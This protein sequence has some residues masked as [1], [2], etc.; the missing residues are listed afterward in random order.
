MSSHKLG[1]ITIDDCP[2]GS[3]SSL[4]TCWLFQRIAFVQNSRFVCGELVCAFGGFLQ[5][6]GSRLYRIGETRSS[7]TM[8]AGIRCSY[9][10]LN[11]FEGWIR[12]NITRTTI[13]VAQCE[14]DVFLFM[15]TAR[16]QLIN[17]LDRKNS[18]CA[19]F[20]FHHPIPTDNTITNWICLVVSS[21]LVTV[22]NLPSYS[23][24]FIN[25]FINLIQFDTI[26][27]FWIGHHQ[28]DAYF[29]SLEVSFEYQ[30]FFRGR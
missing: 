2:S 9:V 28:P 15:P 20:D 7:T 8:Q 12:C 30:P 5:H 1:K 16:T 3:F 4:P 27:W 14:I 25:W 10:S 19:G 22:F 18:F 17:M 11:L 23:G 29:E 6:L 21:T 13:S 24:W 26:L